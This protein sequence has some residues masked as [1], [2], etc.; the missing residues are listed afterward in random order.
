MA[1]LLSEIQWSDPV[2]PVTHDA[3]WEAELKRRGAPVL[4]VD[5]RVAP[6]PWL[7][8]A[9]YQATNYAPGALPERLHRIGSMV[10]AQENSCR[11][12]YGAN[13][14]YMKVLG[15][16][17]SF[18]QQVERDAQMAELDDKE[19][20]YIAFCRSLARSRPRPAAAERAALLKSGYTPAQI[21]E[22]AFAISFGCFY[23]RVSTL[24][25]C[26]PEQKFERMASGPF[27][28]LLAL[29]MPLTKKFAPGRPVQLPMDRADL[30]A[31]PFGVVLEPLAGLGAGR[32]MKAALDGAFESRVLSRR[33]KALMF[34]VVA[35]TL[36]CPHCEAAATRLLREDGLSQEDIDNAMATL[37]SPHLA[38]REAGL[39]AW[40]RDTVYYE[41]ASIQQR[42]R[43]L[44]AELGDAALL[45]AIGVASL[46]NGTVRLAM[47][48]E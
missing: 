16:S 27:R 8:E 43:A 44:G 14:A 39:L 20:A 15:Y 10:T 36:G 6:S 13:R 18:I 26:P 24:L 9:A 23:N 47:L 2:L 25:A 33:A 31:G 19:R 11:Y 12:C 4:E 45:E 30:A 35:R 21:G 32:V 42:T 38:Q 5:R 7:R 48:L 34:A 17:E 28:W 46:A 3:Q 1:V 41:P 22:I 29:A 40:T 37:R